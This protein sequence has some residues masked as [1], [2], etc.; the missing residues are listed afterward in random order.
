ML[1]KPNR[2]MPKSPLPVSD[3]ASCFP[4]QPLQHQS[5]RHHFEHQLLFGPSLL[6]IIPSHRRPVCPKLSGKHVLFLLV[7]V[8]TPLST[9]PPAVRPLQLGLLPSLQVFE[10]HFT[11]LVS[12][13]LALLVTRAVGF[14]KVAQPLAF[15]VS[16]IVVNPDTGRPFGDVTRP[17]DPEFE[18][19]K[20]CDEDKREICDTGFN[21]AVS[22]GPRHP[23]PPRKPPGL[24]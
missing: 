21:N 18:L 16:R 17:D 6:L 20:K 3:I 22:P 15:G 13:V 12:G 9:V 11:A 2:V 5:T 14:D 1:L 8:S 23:F 4:T 10:M 24:L 19:G 7:R